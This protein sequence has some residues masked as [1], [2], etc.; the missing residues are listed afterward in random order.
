MNAKDY[1][2]EMREYWEDSAALW[3]LILRYKSSSRRH[4]QLR[5]T[6]DWFESHDRS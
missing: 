1:A 3:T 6:S 4:S 2:N 5:V